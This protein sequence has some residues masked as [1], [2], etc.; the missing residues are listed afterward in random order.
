MPGAPM[1]LLNPKQPSLHCPDARSREL[2]EKTIAFF[3]AKGKARLRKDDLD[4]TWYADFLAFAAKEKL[5]ATFLSPSSLG[6]E[7]ARWDTWRNCALNEV[8]G[9]YG[10]PYWY[11]WQVS[12]LGLGPIWMSGNEEARRRTARLLDAGGIFG[13]GL[14]EKEHGA[15]IYSTDM[16]LVPDGDGKRVG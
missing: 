7:G 16:E 6:G 15:D 11:T 4:R 9:F 12:I 13:F 5:F 3:E 14:S 1:F 8:L 2:I 10:L